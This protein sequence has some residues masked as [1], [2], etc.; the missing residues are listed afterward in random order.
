MNFGKVSELAVGYSLFLLKSPISLILSLTSSTVNGKSK[1]APSALYHLNF[2][3]NPAPSSKIE[4]F[5][6]H[7][8]LAKYPTKGTIYSAFNISNA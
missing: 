3:I 7:S 1:N 8:S 4:P 5:S 2:A 6:S